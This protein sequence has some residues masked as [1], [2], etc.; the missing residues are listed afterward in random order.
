[1]V[2]DGKK[3]TPGNS[4]QPNTLF[5][6]EQIPGK[7]VGSDATD[8]LAKG[9]WSSYNGKE[10]ASSDLLLVHIKEHER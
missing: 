6:V 3:F 2:L 8:V 9:Y 4:L 10:I 5:V 1:M 7:V